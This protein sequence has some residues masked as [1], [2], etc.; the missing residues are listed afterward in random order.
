MIKLDHNF[1]RGSYTPVV[2]PFRDGK[3][4]YRD[5]GISKGRMTPG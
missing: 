1:L 5:G 4:N 3:V 2:T